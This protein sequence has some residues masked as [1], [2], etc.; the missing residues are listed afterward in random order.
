MSRKTKDILISIVGGL[1]IGMILFSVMI[2]FGKNKYSVVIEN[3]QFK[4]YAT[5]Q[6]IEIGSVLMT[7]IGINLPSGGCYYAM[8][9]VKNEYRNCSLDM[10]CCENVF[11]S[12]T[13]RMNSV[14][15]IPPHK[16]EQK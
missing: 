9:C 7:D 12:S 8:C 6:C 10:L 4:D 16:K 5:K 2:L 14:P 11:D 13:C 3:V 1:I 15:I